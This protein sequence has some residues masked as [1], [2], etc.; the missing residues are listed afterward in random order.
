MPKCPNHFFVL[1]SNAL[2]LAVAPRPLMPHQA[3]LLWS[4]H[5]GG[6]KNCA[7]CTALLECRGTEESGE[8]AGQSQAWLQA[9]LLHL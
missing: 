6:A 9:L 8:T 1:L 4:T 3:S 5:I 7:L 2:S